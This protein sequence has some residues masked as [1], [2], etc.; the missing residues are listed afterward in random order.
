VKRTQG[1]AR[2][3]SGKTEGEVGG[4]QRP[5][6]ASTD[7]CQR[8]FATS[9]EG[10]AAERKGFEPLALM[11]PP[12]SA[13]PF[14][15]ARFLPP[16]N[17]VLAAATAAARGVEGGRRV[18]PSRRSRDNSRGI[19]ESRSPPAPAS[20]QARERAH[21]A[22]PRPAWRARHGG[23]ASRN[24][25]LGG[26]ARPDASAGGSMR[27][28]SLC[29]SKSAA[30]LELHARQHRSCLTESEA[31]LW[32]ALKGRQLGVSFRRDMP[33][34]GSF[35]ADFL[36]PAIGLIVEVDGAYHGRRPGPDS[37]RDPSSVA[38]TSALSVSARGSCYMIC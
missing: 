23:D 19:Y 20:G 13:R 11:P 5:K 16:P 21:A 3:R 38:R 34:G 4:A 6:A 31:R 32:S 30:R 35:I 36:A 9:S 27:A 8:R 1:R 14:G 26:C 33:V 2:A 37:R 17:A 12:S 15:A 24:L 29:N 28:R 22:P 25:R 10:A 18:E 7:G